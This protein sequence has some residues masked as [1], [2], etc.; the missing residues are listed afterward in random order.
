MN[1]NCNEFSY[2]SEKKADQK[3]NILK[4]YIKNMKE[5]SENFENLFKKIINQSSSDKNN[6]L[7]DFPNINK[8]SSEE[9]NNNKDKDNIDMEK[10]ENLS[11]IEESEKNENDNGNENGNGKFK[12]YLETPKNKR[13]NSLLKFDKNLINQ[14]LNSINDRN[15]INNKDNISI[16]KKSS[17]KDIMQIKKEEIFTLSKAYDFDND[18]NNKIVSNFVSENLNS[19]NKTLRNNREIYYGLNIQNDLSIINQNTSKNRESLEEDDND[20]DNDNEIYYNNYNINKEVIGLSQ[21]NDLRYKILEEN[22]S[23]NTNSKDDKEKEYDL[24]K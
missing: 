23:I 1:E 10:N 8:F 9:K 5:E 2:N 7:R 17:V 19:E 11:F 4:D 15:L 18:N 16:G 6:I 12:G 20:N 24:G 13:S 3:K 21:N 14:N 22:N